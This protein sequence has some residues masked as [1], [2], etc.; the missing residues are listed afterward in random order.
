MRAFLAVITLI[1]SLLY[2]SGQSVTLT[3]TVRDSLTREGVPYAS[4]FLRGTDRGVLTDDRG[5]YTITT[6]L[7]FDSV[8][9]SAMGY[10]EK[11]VAVRRKGGTLRLDFD[12]HSSGVQLGTVTVRPRKEHYSKKNNPAVEFMEK[13]RH[14]EDITDP[15]RNDNYN[16]TK[17]ERITLA[18]NDYKPTDSAGRF[19]FLKD[20]VDVNPLSGKPI[21]NVALREK[22]ADV[23]YRHDPESEKEVVKGLRNAGLDEVLNPE[24]TQMFYED[25]LREIDVYQNDI[26]MLQQRFVSPL[27]RISPDFYKFY[28]S[29]TVMVDSVKCV[30]LSFV[31]RNAASM[32]F[33]GRFY[34][35]EGDS[36]MFIKRV[37]MR[38]PHDINLNFIDNL[39]ISQDFAKADD[40]SRLKTRDILQ[41]EASI[42]PGVQGMYAARTTVY[43]GH[44]FNPAADSTVF[45]R[46][47]DQIYD[48]KAFS[49][50]TTFWAEGRTAPIDRGAAH[51]EGMM[52]RLRKVPLY[53]WGEKTVKAF[54]SGYI[55]TAGGK[56]SKF[57]I[58]PLTS[59]VSYNSVE[60]LRLR[61]GGITTA[62]LSKRWFARGYGAYGFHDRKWK[63]RGELEYSFRDK[64][65]HSR[66]FP[67][68]S[69]RLSHQYDMDML[70]QRYVSNN[71]DNLFMSFKRAKDIQMVYRRQSALEYTL[72]LESRFSVAA[73]VRHQRLE[74]TDLMTFTLPTGK[75]LPWY[76]LS[77]ATVE[78]RYAPGEK[79]Y[80]LVTGRLPINLDAPVFTLS[81]TY[82]PKGKLGNRLGLN[83][84]EASFSKRFWLSAFG[85]MDTYLAAGHVWSRSAYPNLLIPNANLS[86]FI[87]AQSFS[88]LNP[89]EFINDSYAQADV[90]YW[91][92]GALLNLI[93]GVKRLKL[94]EALFCR[95]LWGH[96]SEKNQPGMSNPDLFMFPAAAHTQLMRKDTPFIEASVG[97]DNLFKFLRVDY[98]WRLTYRNAPYAC[99]GGLRFMIHLSF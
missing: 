97:L 74:A 99:R 55:P 90:T 67:V 95:A 28:L 8:Q 58:G 98:T 69:L 6:A 86:Y 9:A 75:S 16:Y 73:T 49:R 54:A 63:Y 20:Y 35:P 62:N 29:D 13:I 46:K 76:D 33:T 11:T 68:H 34:I 19:G 66:E 87:Q 25:V 40:G 15:R 84:T 85:F 3:G 37:T 83:V 21:L 92:N 71:Q 91:A 27:S 26:T 22:V 53:Y 59:T 5:R 51:I 7:R 61:L 89:M 10:D 36:T 2:A 47:L 38:V 96:L 42:I 12:L 48:P 57:D 80:Q 93:P 44:N 82:A 56:R 79:F 4:I 72:E 45:A 17:Y 81:H 60:G 31:P 24:S 64:K 50:D 94:R 78:L 41:I 52:A 32:G 39:L 23:H 14:S 1:F 70:G 88:T 65:Y 77:S 30:E 43:T 18:L